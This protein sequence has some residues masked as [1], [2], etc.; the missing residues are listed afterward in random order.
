MS[1]TTEQ[2][3]RPPRIAPAT[4]RDVAFVRRLSAEVFGRF[5]RY[6]SLLP[7]I[8]PLPR[9]RTA[10]A[11]TGGEPSGFA[12]YSLEDTANGEV[13]LVAIAVEPARQSRGVGRALLRFVESEA[14]ALSGE[15][16]ASVRLTVAEDND[17]ARALFERSGYLPIPGEHGVYDGGQRSMG[18]RKRLRRA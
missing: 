1:G 8:M 10:I 15:G 3:S 9:M 17:A 18:L 6:D 7:S 12:M 2:D 11:T 4:A 14:L 13:D 5:G 16:P